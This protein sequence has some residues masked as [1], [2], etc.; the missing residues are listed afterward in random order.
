MALMKVGEYNPNYR[1]EIFEGHDIKGYDVYAGETND[2]IGTVKDALVDETGHFRYLVID[3]GFWI[4]GKQVLL[5]IGRSRI[6]YNDKNV[7]ALGIT[8]KAQAENLPE[9]REDMTVDYDYEER[10]RAG[11]RPAPAAQPEY[12]RETYDYDRDR[13][14][15]ETR[16]TD[17]GALRL[18]EERLVTGKHRAKTGEVGLGKRVETETAHASIPVDKERVVIDRTQPRDAGRAVSPQEADFREGEV[19]R[20]EIHEER[21]DIRKEPFVREEV[22]MRKEVEH[23]TVEAEEQVRHEELEI[24]SE[25]N[26]V[27]ERQ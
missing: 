23:D 18:Y 22:S 4:F 7:Y 15:Y 2:K 10:V 16:E 19:A 20:A 8:N 6:N 13:E 25:G 11:Y 14:L 24:D 21:A 3:T 12:S 27:V 17:H 5:P 26:P 9:Y 1:E